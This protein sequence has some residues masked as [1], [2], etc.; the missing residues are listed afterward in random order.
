MARDESLLKENGVTHVVNTAQGKRFGQVN[1]D[2]DFYSG[3]GI[4]YYGIPG[5]D[6]VKFDIS[7]Y[8][9]EAAD[10]ISEGCAKGNETT[11]GPM[12]D[13]VHHKLWFKCLGPYSLDELLLAKS[14]NLSIC[15][16]SLCSLSSGNKPFNDCGYCLSH[17]T[18][19]NGRFGG[20]AAYF[21]KQSSDA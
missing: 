19:E 20:I 21:E 8:F 16:K 11:L 17:V 6:S 2:A 7:K 1:T 4:S 18:W 14:D 9:Q 15:R 5:H 10:F 13:G 3:S 12:P